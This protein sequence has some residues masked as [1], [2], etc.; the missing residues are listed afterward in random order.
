MAKYITEEQTLIFAERLGNLSNAM[1][2]V[3]SA[4]DLCDNINELIEQ[5]LIFAERLGNLSNA[6]V[7]VTSAVDLCDN[8]NE[9]IE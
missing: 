5:T 8:I 9:L 3:T 4:V 1:V 7:Y 6:M 2:Y